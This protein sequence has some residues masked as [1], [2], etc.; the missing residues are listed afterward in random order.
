MCGRFSQTQSPDAIAAA[1]QLSAIP[2][3]TPRYN[4]APTQAVSVVTVSR[5]SG[6]RVHHAKR[7]GLIPRWAKDAAIGA[8]LI[9]A[10][11]E[12]VAE[13]PAFRD[14]F[15]RRRCLVVA[16]GFYE[17]LRTGD[18]GTK[19]P[20]YLH[21]R[22]R[23]PFAFAGLW[24]RWRDPAIA[25]PRFSCTILTTAPNAL[26]API[27]NRMPVIL[28]PS[29]YDL[30][31]DPTLD[32]PNALTPLLRPYEADEMEAYPVST[33]VNNARN[34]SPACLAPLTSEVLHPETE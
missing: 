32:A 23:Q 18:R 17:W 20:F 21:L 27:H 6:D 1:F 26:M 8:R 5:K 22:D 2:D 28:P 14:A 29:A 13:K 30:W 7:W 12:T 3:L 4:I 11:A 25:E 10:R 31:L 34:D 33:H 16:D 24:E 15:Q 19:Q 9:N